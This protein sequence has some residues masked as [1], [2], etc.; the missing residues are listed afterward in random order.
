MNRLLPLSII[1]S[2]LTKG[3]LDKLPPSD[4]LF[5]LE[6][7]KN[8]NSFL[9]I[10][11]SI[12]MFVPCDDK[13]PIMD[14]EKL[15]NLEPHEDQAFFKGFKVV[16]NSEICNVLTISN[17]VASVFWY[18]NITKNWNPSR[19]IKTLEDLTPYG[20]EVDTQVKLLGVE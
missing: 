9:K 18:D 2:S 11:I 14:E 12:D 5:K 7:I 3:D 16:C 13:G 15:Q 4:I 20:F 8:Y 1:V 19:G 17:G 6:E 10:P